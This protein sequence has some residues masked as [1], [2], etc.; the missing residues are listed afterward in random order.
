[1]LMIRHTKCPREMSS[2]PSFAE[3]VVYMLPSN[4]Q[5]NGNTIN[6]GKQ[7]SPGPKTSVLDEY[8]YKLLLELTPCYVDFEVLDSAW[9]EWLRLGEYE[10][11]ESQRR[12]LLNTTK[13]WGKD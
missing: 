6:S 13:P 9:K 4:E 10:H 8:H 7:C 5:S 12:S 11:G 1:M 3:L 2:N